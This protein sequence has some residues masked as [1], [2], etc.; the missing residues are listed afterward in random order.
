MCFS[1]SASFT[2]AAIVGAAGVA[3]LAKVKSRRQLILGIFPLLFALQQFAEGLIWLY[4]D[5][6]KHAVEVGKY[7][8]VTIAYALWPLFTPLGFAVLEKERY[9]KIALWIVCGIG[10]CVFLCELYLLLT[11]SI[12]MQ[13]KGSSLVYPYSL[14]LSMN[15]YLFGMGLYII[16]TLAPPFISSLKKARLFGVF[17]VLGLIVTVLFYS[18]VQASVFCFVSAFMS[19]FIYRI[20]RDD[21]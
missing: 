13:V 8:Y 15:A 3:T 14:P 2:A 12:A 18:Y 10:A 17:L 5:S 9:R 11:T 1:A 19:L 7:T 20:I 21:S 6:N 16:S 4:M